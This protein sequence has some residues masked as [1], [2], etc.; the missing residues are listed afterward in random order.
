MDDY[1]CAEPNAMETRIEAMFM[2]LAIDWQ[3]ANSAHETASLNSYA[4]KL[5]QKMLNKE[6][7]GS[8]A[9]RGIVH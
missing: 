1:L 5:K 2:S 9:K 6:L 3:N 8:K 7:N 4:T